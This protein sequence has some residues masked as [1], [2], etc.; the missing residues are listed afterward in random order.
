MKERLGFNSN[1]GVELLESED[2]SQVRTFERSDPRN[3]RSG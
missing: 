3:K 2:F 1:H